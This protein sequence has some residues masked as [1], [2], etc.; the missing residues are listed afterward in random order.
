MD[1]R[2]NVFIDVRRISDVLLSVGKDRHF[3]AIAA[4]LRKEMRLWMPELVTLRFGSMPAEPPVDHLAGRPGK[5][6]ENSDVGGPIGENRV[7][8]FPWKVSGLQEAIGFRSRKNVACA[9]LSLS[10][11]SFDVIW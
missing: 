7:T 10:E 8:G 3:R 9:G 1:E 6:G 4:H 2:A 5:P 11:R